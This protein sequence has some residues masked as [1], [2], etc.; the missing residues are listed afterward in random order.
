MRLGIDKLSRKDAFIIG[1][2]QALALV[3][4][5]SRSGITIVTGLMLRLERQTSARFSFLLN[6]SLK[7][8]ACYRFFIAFVIIIAIWTGLKR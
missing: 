5:V 6:H 4:G 3:P 8:F 7:P 1:V 2:A